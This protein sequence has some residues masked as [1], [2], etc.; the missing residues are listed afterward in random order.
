MRSEACYTRTLPFEDM[1]QY[2]HLGGSIDSNKCQVFIEFRQKGYYQN[3]QIVILRQPIT[4]RAV[5]CI[6]AVH[7][8]NFRMLL[9]GK[10]F[11]S[12]FDDE[13]ISHTHF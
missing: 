12:S 6:D 3:I 13:V 1:N 2:E 10:E 9:L 11:F 8:I 5:I 4:S 7:F